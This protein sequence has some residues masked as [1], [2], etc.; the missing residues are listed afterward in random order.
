MDL[1]GKS[2]NYRNSFY[3]QFS[4]DNLEA[5]TL[6][7]LNK[8]VDV[9]SVKSLESEIDDLTNEF[10]G[11]EELAKNKYPVLDDYIKSINSTIK[12]IDNS[13]SKQDNVIKGI[14]VGLSCLIKKGS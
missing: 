10:S 13:I 7:N 1:E 8:Q 3:N 12:D 5:K 6:F 11:L 14:R 9:E 2:I 4:S